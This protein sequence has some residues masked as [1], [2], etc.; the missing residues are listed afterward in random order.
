MSQIRIQRH[1]AGRAVMARLL[2]GPV[3]MVAQ[4][5]RTWTLPG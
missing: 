1:F 4:I 3:S 2:S 5:V